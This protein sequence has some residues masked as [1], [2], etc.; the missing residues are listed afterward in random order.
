M[1]TTK[2]DVRNISKEIITEFDQRATELNISRNDLLLDV[3]ND[4]ADRLEK[5]KYANGLHDELD[6]LIESVN[7]VAKA[8]ELNTLALGEAMTELLKQ[9]TTYRT[10]IWNYWQYDRGILKDDDFDD[11]TNAILTKNQMQTDDDASP[12]YDEFK[13][14]L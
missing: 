9:I 14:I 1:E 7:S 10:E 5:K 2:I 13:D 8:N 12:D 11:A 3:L 4:Y 6:D